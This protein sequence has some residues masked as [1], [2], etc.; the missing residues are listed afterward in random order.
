MLNRIMRT[1]REKGQ[2]LTE[3]VLIL[4]FIAGIAFMMFGGNGSLKDTLVNTFTETHNILAGLF[5]EEGNLYLDTI[6]KYGKIRN[7]DEIKDPATK[8]QRL[9]ADQMALGNIAEFFIGKDRDYVKKILGGKDAD[10]KNGSV[11]LG[12]YKFTEDGGSEW[13]NDASNAKGWLTD[14][15]KDE[16]F[17]WMQ[18]DY[19]TYVQK[20]GNTAAHVTGYN[21]LQY[22]TS[23]R[24]LFSDYTVSN[25][26]NGLADYAATG[27]VKL[28][29]QYEGDTVVGAKIAIDSLS[30]GSNKN[31]ASSGLEVRVNRNKEREAKNSALDGNFTVNSN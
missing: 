3:Y 19:G 15:Y 16:I 25:T 27:G 21:N 23:N 29:L 5:S 4:A 2:G 9:K 26:Y 12:H 28:R 17:H 8:D 14:D 22:D 18:G 10:T 31:Y 11:L 20:E 13:Y 24:Y 30:Q 1:I 7:E 6:K